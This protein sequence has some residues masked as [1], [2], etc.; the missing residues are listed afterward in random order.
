MAN[1]TDI[2][3]YFSVEGHPVTNKELIEFR[4]GNPE[5]YNEIK[6]LLDAEDEVMT[7]QPAN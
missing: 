4:K 1:A 2:K 6:K 5:G 3:N 7:D